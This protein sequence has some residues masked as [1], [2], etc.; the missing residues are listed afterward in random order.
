[1]FTQMFRF[2]LLVMALLQVAAFAP[3]LGARAL[4]TESSIVMMA[5]GKANPALFKTGL[6]GKKKEAPKKEVKL[7]RRGQDGSTIFPKPWEKSNGGVSS[8]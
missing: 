6:E 4:Q 8:K 1:M 2:L 7:E 3:G 5:K